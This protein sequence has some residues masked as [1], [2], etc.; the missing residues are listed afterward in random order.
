MRFLY[1][2]ARLA[3][4]VAA[5]KRRPSIY[6]KKLDLMFAPGAFA[7]C[8]Q[9]ARAECGLTLRELAELTGISHSEIYKIE[10]G[11]RECRLESLVHIC[12]ALGLPVGRLIDEITLAGAGFHSTLPNDPAFS[13]LVREQYPVDPPSIALIASNLAS[14]CGLALHLTRCAYATRAAG[15]IRYPVEDLKARFLAYASRVDAIESPLARLKL[16]MGLKSNPI[17]SLASQ[18]LLSEKFVK[19]V[20][21]AAPVLNSAAGLLSF[22]EAAGQASGGMIWVPLPEFAFSPSHHDFK[23]AESSVDKVPNSEYQLD[24]RLTWKQLKARLNK[25][26]EPRGKRAELARAVDVYQSRLNSWLDDVQEP[27]AEATFRLLEWVIAEEAK[28]KSSTGALTPVEQTARTEKDT[29][30][31]TKQSEPPKGWPSRRKKAIPR[32]S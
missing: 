20:L 24:V 23:R 8:V 32:K 6:N 27:G 13:E 11:G 7:S 21:E 28:T 3:S 5:V 22:G 18:N 16:A 19:H 15:R 31:E 30:N 29:A 10:S 26:T 14:C 12:A 2:P 1:L 25:A 9:G 17:Q 4:Y